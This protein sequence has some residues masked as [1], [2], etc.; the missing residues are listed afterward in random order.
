MEDMSELPPH[1]DKELERITQL[2]DS[3]A[4]YDEGAI[5]EAATHLKQNPND[6]GELFIQ[7]FERFNNAEKA[8]SVDLAGILQAANIAEALARETPPNP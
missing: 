2:A 8:R 1:T 3:V 7:L 4:S 6:A 5:E